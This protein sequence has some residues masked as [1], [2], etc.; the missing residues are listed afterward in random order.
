[1]GRKEKPGIGIMER[2]KELGARISERIDKWNHLCEFGGTD[3][4]CTDGANMNLVRNHIRIAKT[5][6]EKELNGDYPEEYYYPT[7]DI[8]DTEYMARAEE[9]T[10]NAQKTLEIYKTHPDYL[11]LI[12]IMGTMDEAQKKE[13]YIENATGYVDDLADFIKKKNLVGMRRH[14]SPEAVIDGFKE[15]R[16]KTEIVLLRPQAEKKSVVKAKKSEPVKPAKIPKIPVYTKA[17]QKSSPILSVMKKAEKVIGK[18]TATGS[19]PS[20]DR[21]KDIE[22]MSIFSFLE[23]A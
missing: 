4:L 10:Q 22:Q 11:W 12:K 14:E 16:R 19:I 17:A 5:Q 6:C 2:K 15:C 21:I 18:A 1:M 7:P 8:V 3:R 13:T 23:M 9:I 20:E